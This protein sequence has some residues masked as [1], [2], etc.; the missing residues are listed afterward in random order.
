MWHKSQPEEK[1][2]EESACKA[3]AAAVEWEFDDIDEVD[4]VRV[5]RRVK[6]ASMLRENDGWETALRRVLD[7]FV[8]AA[9]AYNNASATAS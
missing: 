5:V 3:V 9:E 8:A 2:E 4:T 7:D 1:E 6:S